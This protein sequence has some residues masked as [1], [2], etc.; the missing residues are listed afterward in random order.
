MKYLLHHSDAVY[1]SVTKKWVFTLDRRISN[2]RSIRISAC[3]FTAS[4]AET[5]PHVVYMRSDT[6]T[7]LCKIK[8]TIEVKGSDHENHSNVIAVLEQTLAG[9]YA[10]KDREGFLPV[11][12]HTAHTRSFDIFFTDGD[13]ILD[14]EVSTTSSVATGDDAAIEAIPN[15]KM[16]ID[17]A[18]A[19]LLDSNYANAVNFGD[20][21]RYIYQN[22]HSEV[23]TFT[24]YGDFDLTA[25]GPN[26][27]RGLSSQVSWQFANETAGSNWLPQEDFTLVFGF[28]APASA[29]TGVHRITRFWWLDMF[30]DQGVFAIEDAA[31]NRQSTGLT[32]VPTKDYIITV[33]RADDDG[34]G[35]YQ[36]YSRSE[37]L[38][39]NVVSNGTSVGIGR[40]VS[41]QYAYY[42]SLAN[43]HFLDKTGV[44][45][46]LI[47]FLGGNDSTN[48]AE[49]ETWIRNKYN[50]T[51]TS[52]SGE[53][54]SVNQDATFFVSLDVKQRN[55]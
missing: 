17:M 16:W 13:T 44:L 38:D 50:G 51:S 14:G 49:C 7:R 53:T 18:P 35:V 37:R 52:E 48:V 22:A 3:T 10:L 55:V 33:R 25:W 54:V 41:Q 21:V 30:I 47:F 42:L 8:H 40:P 31:G 9:K 46:Y 32:I 26:G 29:L 43:E 1:N 5:Y 27:A 19:N 2:P 20:P 6:L 12:G 15:V 39:N 23:N 28:K 45:S 11:H 36:F 24:G 4:T 34:D